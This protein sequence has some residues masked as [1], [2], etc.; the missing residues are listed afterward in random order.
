M[1]CFN[2]SLR[3][4][5][6]KTLAWLITANPKKKSAKKQTTANIGAVEVNNRIGETGVHLR[7]HNGS[8]YDRLSGAQRAELH[9]WRHYSAVKHSAT[10][11]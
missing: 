7:L 5:F 4:S 1:I 9:N 8:E 6:D 3:N 10:G 11:Y 2:P